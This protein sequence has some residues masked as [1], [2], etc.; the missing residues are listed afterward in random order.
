MMTSNRT[1]TTAVALGA[2]YLLA[3]AGLV[4][5]G[6]GS[7]RRAPPLVGPQA[8]ASQQQQAGRRA[9]IEK[10]DFC[11]PGGEAGLGPALNDKPLPATAIKLQV[12]KGL[13]AM[14]DFTPQ[15]LTDGDLQQVADYVV[16]LRRAD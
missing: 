12:R 9:F 3:L 14:P 2:A 15:E 4:A 11:H 5:G 13:G 6:C 10:C 16:A 7:A 8:A 1:R